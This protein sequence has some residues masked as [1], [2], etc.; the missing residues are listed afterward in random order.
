MAGSRR[1]FILVK[2]VQQAKARKVDKFI[3]NWKITLLTENERVLRKI[4][5]SLS[6]FFLPSVKLKWPLCNHFTFCLQRFVFQ[7]NNAFTWKSVFSPKRIEVAVSEQKHDLH[8]VR[9][10]TRVALFVCFFA[11]VSVFGAKFVVKWIITPKID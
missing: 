3:I 11:L 2:L 10:C 9:E 5:I 7:R 8:C 1:T 4:T 6:V